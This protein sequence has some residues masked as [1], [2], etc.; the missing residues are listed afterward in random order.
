MECGNE[1][2]RTIWQFFKV[3]NK[4]NLRQFFMRLSSYTQ[5][6]S[7][8]LCQSSLRIHSA[9]ASYDRS[10]I[11]RPQLSFSMG[12]CERRF[13]RAFFIKSSIFQRNRRFQGRSQGRVLGVPRE[14]PLLLLKRVDLRT[15]FQV[16]FIITLLT[17]MKCLSFLKPLSVK[18]Q[19]RDLHVYEVDMSRIE[20]YSTKCPHW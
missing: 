6:I 4:T 12:T 8:W 16:F 2:E 18:L 7:S 3:I 5:Q 17:A 15:P 13:R 14:P 1:R 19:K 10:W 9:I 11:H 20:R